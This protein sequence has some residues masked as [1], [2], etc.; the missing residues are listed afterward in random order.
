MAQEPFNEGAEQNTERAR[1]RFADAARLRSEG[2]RDAA[3]RAALEGVAL[4]RAM[5]GLAD[6][7]LGAELAAGVNLL[8]AV[9]GDAGR[10][11]EALDAAQEA[12]S[13]FRELAAANRA[14]FLPDLAASLDNLGI[15]LGKL[16]RRAEAPEAAQEAVVLCRELVAANRLAFLPG[17]A[18]S[19]NTLGATLGE[20]GR[21]AE[22]LEAARESVS[23]HRELVAMNRSAFLPGL[24]S[25]LIN[26]GNSVSK[27]R[28]HVEALQAAEEAVGLYRDLAT[29]DRPAFLPD[30]ARRLNNLGIRL[31]EVGRRAE[32]LAVAQEAVEL[33]RELAAA[34]RAAHLPD[35]AECLCNL[36]DRLADAGRRAEALRAF[37]E[38]G[39]LLLEWGPADPYL[40]TEIARGPTRNLQTPDDLRRWHLPLLGQLVEHWELAYD[41]T[42]ARLFLDLQAEVVARTWDLLA[43]LAPGDSEL[44]EQG[45]AVLVTSL[46]A[47]DLSSWPQKQAMPDAAGSADVNGQGPADERSRLLRDVIDA[48]RVLDALLARLRHEYGGDPGD[49]MVGDSNTADPPAL[50]EQEGRGMTARNRLETEIARQSARARE[51][52]DAWRAARVGLIAADAR[53][54]VA[55]ARLS[56]QALRACAGHAGGD[57]VLC[58]L[59]IAVAGK[60]ARAIGVLLPADGRPARLLDL[61][62][63]VDLLSKADWPAWSEEGWEGQLPLEH[64]SQA[65]RAALWVPLQ[66]AL[67]AIQ[68]GR[69]PPRRLHLCLPTALQ[70]LPLALREPRDCPDLDIVAWP[71][72]PSL[73]SASRR[74]RGGDART[75]AA[76]WVIGHDCAWSTRTPMPMA[77]LEAALLRDLLLAQGCVVEPIGPGVPLRRGAA[78]LL[79]AAHCDVGPPGTVETLYLGTTRLTA[80]DVLQQGLDPGLVLLPSGGGRAWATPGAVPDSGVGLAQAFLLAGSR[81]VVDAGRVADLLQPWMST[82]MVWLTLQGMPPRQAALTARERFAKLAFPDDYRRWLQQALPAALATIQPGGQEARQILGPW[83]MRAMRDTRVYWPW[84]GQAEHL[85]SS[86]R[87]RREQATRSVAEGVLVPHGGAAG[88]SALAAAMREMAA[89]V[90]VF[91]VD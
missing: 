32:A 44:V 54:Q 81:V 18:S 30:V 5:D 45:I 27:A 60:V 3:V 14:A 88:A 66:Q 13:L 24:A 49:S 83:A 56:S 20:A 77:A 23:L 10:R 73:L 68:G 35:L 76:P 6:T 89:F 57:A 12:V 58:M 47:P 41:S 17:L 74:R 62:G 19:L 31:S 87:Q 42:H 59:T 33:C 22:A 91:G 52:R 51:A 29:A 7:K 65:L 75:R 37:R 46:H 39:T 21:R 80:A 61:P 86:D 16:G 64:L 78:A 40:W 34:N 55:L 79:L 25:S 38:C 36:G 8:S 70:G 63:L 84:E 26:L 11:A 15:R 4:L 71:G 69:P 72:W 28:R 9:L 43:A 2:R 48:E 53:P 82:L 1:E 90:R 67:A 85:F 50:A